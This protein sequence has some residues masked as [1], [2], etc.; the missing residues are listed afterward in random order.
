MRIQSLDGLR[1]IAILSVLLIHH[2]LFNNGWMGVDLF[3]VL[4][5]FLITQILRRE[6]DEPFY[7]RR[8][9]V[10]RATRIL[11]PLV[12]TVIL[13]YVFTPKAHLLAAVGYLLS[14][15]GL[16]ELTPYHILPLGPLWSL[17]VEEH[18]YLLW[19]FAVRY[20][21]RKHLLLILSVTIAVVPLLR[22]YFSHP[23][24]M[25][26]LTPVYFLTPFRIDEMSFGCLLAILLESQSSLAFLKQ[27]SK[28]LFF[29]SSGT[30]LVIWSSLHHV[31]YFPGAHTKFFDATGYTLVAVIC[32]SAVAHVRLNRDNWVSRVLSFAPLAFVGRISYGIYLYHLLIKT[33]VMWTMHITSQQMALLGDFPLVLLV[34]W[35][36]FK[37]YESPIIE[38]GKHRA[39]AYRSTW[40]SKRRS[41]VAHHRDS[42]A[43]SRQIAVA[44]HTA[45]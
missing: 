24:P 18:F 26:E 25:A 12:L 19:P 40:V 10:K 4:S 2:S 38:W 41:N 43:L 13:G 29:L 34:S 3:F 27:W 20:L 9:Y 8:F 21:P 30:Y 39:D 31:L 1:G 22:M 32:F 15:S 16:I 33:L 36:S 23:M 35:L 17:A 6:A 45:D 28:W 14:L 11:P 37:Y 7:W 42:K 5:G 44:A